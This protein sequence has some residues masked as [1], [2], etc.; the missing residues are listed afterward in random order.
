MEGFI[1][2]CKFLGA[3]VMV[4]IVVAILPIM[5]IS[6]VQGRYTCSNYQKV[7]GTET[8]WVLLDECY[9]KTPQGWQRYDEFK[10]L[11][12]ASEGMNEAQK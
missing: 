6:E 1:D 4:F 10:A 7:T 5:A 12:I 2:F 9:I 8:R 11:A 3:M